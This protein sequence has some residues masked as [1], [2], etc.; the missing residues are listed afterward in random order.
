MKL[1]ELGT[2]ISGEVKSRRVF[3]EELKEDLEKE[4]L[5]VLEIS[6]SDMECRWCT[7]KRSEGR[8]TPMTRNLFNSIRDTPTIKEFIAG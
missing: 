4:G 7:V 1:R 3:L 8:I 2:I 5:E 6:E